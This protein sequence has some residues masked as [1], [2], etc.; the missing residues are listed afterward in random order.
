[1]TTQ[2]RDEIDYVINLLNR[3]SAKPERYPA[4][5]I[6]MATEAGARLLREDHPINY[7]TP[8]P[9]HDGMVSLLTCIEGAPHGE[10]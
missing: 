8:P 5:I 3:I 7:S 9:P 2:K 4:A 6:S 1:M 10:G